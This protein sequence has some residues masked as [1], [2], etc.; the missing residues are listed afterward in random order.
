MKEIGDP[1]SKEAAVLCTYFRCD[2]NFTPDTKRMP[3]EQAREFA[4]THEG[5][6]TSE[7]VLV[8]EDSSHAL[9]EDQKLQILTL[10][11]VAYL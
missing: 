5:E 6:T 7:T 2:L 11:G 1:T 10:T 4:Q 8:L 9:T 3:V